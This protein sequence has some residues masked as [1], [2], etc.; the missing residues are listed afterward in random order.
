MLCERCKKNPA[1]FHKSLNINGQVYETHLCHEC[2]NEVDFEMCSFSFND[3]DT[4]FEKL[5][6]SIIDEF[7]N[8]DNFF[9]PTRLLEKN[10]K[11]CNNCGST[12]NDFLSRGRLGCANCYD[13]FEE[14]IR[15]MLEN[16]DNPTDF[17]LDID[18]AVQAIKPSELEQLQNDFN[19]AIEEERYEDAGEIKKKINKM[20]EEK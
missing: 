1:T 6:N 2:A 3:F 16:M 14:E 20:K 13:V 5:E 7:F 9:T 10:D 4:Q 19:K 8:L 18:S 12:F 11:K 17:S 15:D